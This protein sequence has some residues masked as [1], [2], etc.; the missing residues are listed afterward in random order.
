MSIYE[1]ASH[2]TPQLFNPI[3]PSLLSFTIHLTMHSIVN[4]KINLGLNIIRKRDDGFH[5]LQTVF[6]PTDAFSDL[7]SLEPIAG[8]LE[9]VCDSAQDIG[10]DS[11]N[12]CV[13]AF[14][15]LER[16]FGVQGVRL[17]LEKHIPT[18][19]GVGGGSADAAFVL[20][21]LTEQFKL[22]LDNVDLKQYAAQLGSDVPFFI[23]NKPA[24][25]EGRG[26]IMTPVD[27]DLSA[28]NI[29]IE[30]PEVSVST[31]EAYAHVRP[32][33]SDVNFA[34]VVRNVPVHEWKKYLYN[35][36][37]DSVFPKYPQIAEIKRKFYESG[38][39]YAAMSGSGSAVFGIFP[40]AR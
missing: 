25:A 10:P 32:H 35:D 20:K 19:A 23:D 36:F 12:L 3:Y 13:K 34:E 38:A 7:L 30:K 2:R 18:G 24:F 16:D 31:R 21:M 1:S 37:E 4:C 29:I 14:R 27:L 9:F 15:L 22:P 5:D 26:E 28:Y 6:Y 39:L 17:R 8:G 11:D 33:E 40:K